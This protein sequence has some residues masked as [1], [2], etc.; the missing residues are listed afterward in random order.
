MGTRSLHFLWL[1]K[2]ERKRYNMTQIPSVLTVGLSK[3][4]RRRRA[5]LREENAYMQ[6]LDLLLLCILASS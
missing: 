3:D 2:R 5:Y 6:E 1:S 4:L